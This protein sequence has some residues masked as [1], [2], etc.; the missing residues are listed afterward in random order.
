MMNCEKAK[1]LVVA[2]ALAD[3]DSQSK[4]YWQLRDHL[5]CCDTC[6]DLYNTCLH[7]TDFIKIHKY[8]FAEALG[9][10]E[11]NITEEQN[12][13]DCSWQSIEIKLKETQASKKSQFQLRRAIFAALSAAAC[14]AIAI[15]TWL[16]TSVPSVTKEL[17]SK[18]QNQAIGDQMK[19]EVLSQQTMT[20]ISTEAVINTTSNQ[21]KSLIINRKYQLVMNV[22]TRL[23]I[24]P[25]T[26]TDC[27]GCLV[28]LDSGEILV[29]AKRNSGSFVVS[30]T[31]GKAIIQS[32]FFDVLTTQ[33]ATKLAV[34]NGQVRFESEKGAV[35]VQAGYMSEIIGPSV[36]ARP[37]RCDIAAV[38]AWSAEQQMKFSRPSHGPDSDWPWFS[39][40]PDSVDLYGIEYNPWIEENKDWFRCEFPWIFKLQNA[41]AES[42]IETDYGRLTI[43]SGDAWQF[44]YPPISPRQ[45]SVFD[46]NSFADLAAK[47]GF[48]NDWVAQNLAPDKFRL[49]RTE[50]PAKGLEAFR[51]WTGSFQNAKKSHG[52]S[53][54]SETLLYSLQ[55]CEHLI[56]TRT[57]IWLSKT[58]CL[59]KRWGKDTEKICEL[60]QR[61]IGTTCEL[62]SGIIELLWTDRDTRPAKY[63]QLLD[64]IIK[65]LELITTIEKQI[66]PFKASN[67]QLKPSTL[68]QKN[69]AT[70]AAR[71]HFSAKS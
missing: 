1:I 19:V 40:V 43:D 52:K 33:T 62:R 66:R 25:L 34:G 48:D 26:E 11:K 9:N 13:L 23:S 4:Q 67:K 42:R 31:H 49:S 41:L 65:H 35:Q 3:L 45:F 44:I 18:Q 58:D 29:S 53:L 12:K 46:P 50:T 69:I 15:G 36:P 70:T 51:R 68:A 7:F 27:P 63:S 56:Q 38:I 20:D 59:R 30:T 8:E 61:Q 54:A 32:A 39:P 60:L 22:N 55:A 64:R 47:Y 57:L 21:I 6:T 5:A 37:V 14:L 10:I 17:S 24:E 28:K 2:C 71:A 16:F